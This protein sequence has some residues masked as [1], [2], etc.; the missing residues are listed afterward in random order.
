MSRGKQ[1]ALR[2]S[3]PAVAPS[4]PSTDSSNE[5]CCVICWDSQK[6]TILVPCGH[7]AFCQAC[8]DGIVECAICRAR[9]EK[10][11]KVFEG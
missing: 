5:S 11:V 7:Y 6:T 10:R 8:A 1:I 3:M 9:I 2:D 4:T